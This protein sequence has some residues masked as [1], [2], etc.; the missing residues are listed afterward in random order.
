LYAAADVVVCR[1]GGTTVAEVAA[2]GVP[3]IFVPLPGAP[4]DHQTGNARVFAAVDAARLVPDS[5]CSGDR[6]A[7]ELT[8]ILDDPDQRQAMGRAA[9]GLANPDAALRVAELVDSVID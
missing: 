1:A 5:E 4:G 3:A 9:R 6:L 7:R 8:P 2:A